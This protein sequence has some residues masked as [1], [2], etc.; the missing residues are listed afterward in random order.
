MATET[1]KV[2]V[3]D[4]SNIQTYSFR[5]KN[6]NVPVVNGT[7]RFE[8]TVGEMRYLVW[9]MTGAPGGSMKVEVFR[10]NGTLHRARPQSTIPNSAGGGFDRLRIQI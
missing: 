9:A 6:A 10:A 7:G 5:F 3:S 4:K 2:V 1:L 8:A